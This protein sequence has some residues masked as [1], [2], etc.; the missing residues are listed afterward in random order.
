MRRLDDVTVAP[1]ATVR[2]A[3]GGNHLMLFG[4]GELAP[5]TE[6]ILHTSDGREIPVAFRPI[7]IGGN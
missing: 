5:E 4:V 6:L 2:F 1:G 3:P 7:P